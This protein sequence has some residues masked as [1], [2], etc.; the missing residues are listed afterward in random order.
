MMDA[1]HNQR[2]LVAE[3]NMLKCLLLRGTCLARDQVLRGGCPTREQ[4][5]LH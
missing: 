5:L 1:Q 4:G 2:G 3:R